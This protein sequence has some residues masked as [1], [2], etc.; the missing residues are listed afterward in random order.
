MYEGGKGVLPEFARFEA[1]DKEDGVDDVGLAVAIGPDDAVEML[2]EG[3]KSVFSAV[4]F[5]VDHLEL[6]NDHG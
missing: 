5:E 1:K 2:V 4:G 6:V 3:A